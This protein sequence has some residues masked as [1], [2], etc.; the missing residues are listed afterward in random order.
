MNLGN[1]K[2]GSLLQKYVFFIASIVIIAITVIS[3]AGYRHTKKEMTGSLYREMLL[4]AKEASSVMNQLLVKERALTQGLAEATEELLDQEYVAK[5]YEKILVEFVGVYPET[6]GM[7]IGF[8]ENAFKNLKKAAPYAYRDGSTIVPTDEYTTNDFNIWSTEWYKVGTNN[9]KDGGWTPV[10]K[11]PV[12]G[13]SMATIS[14]PIYGKQNALMGCVASDVDIS[15]LKDIVSTMKVGYGG[16]PFLLSNTGDFLTGEDDEFIS[17]TVQNHS[18]SE[19]TQGIKAMLS[20]QEAGFFDFEDQKNDFIIFHAPVQETGWHVILQFNKK[21][22]LASLHDLF[23]FFIVI[24]IISVIVLIVTVYLFTRFVV[25]RPIN[26]IRERLKDIAQGEGD[27]TMRLN[28]KSKDELGE[29][30]SWFDVFMEKM[31]SIIS[32][33]ANDT[34]ELDKSFRDLSGI[35]DELSSHT[36]ASSDRASNVAVVT[37]ELNS[38]ITTV[39]SAMEQATSNASAVGSASEEMSVTISQIV[40]NVQEASHISSSAV[41]Q[42]KKTAEQMGELEQTALAISNITETITDISDKTNLLA[43]NATIEAA[44]AG[45]AGK[46]FA[47]VAN[48]I[49]ELAAQ[50]VEATNDIKN[51]ISG[52]QGTSKISIAAIH[53]IATIINKVN[54]IIGV[55]TTAVEE[56]SL[57]ARDI[58]ANISQSNQ[59]FIEINEHVNQG[60]SIAQTIST[61]INQVSEASGQIA[62]RSTSLTSEAKRLEE[63]STALK[64]I[65]NSFKV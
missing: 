4:Q 44:R 46:G 54:T 18:N 40:E 34:G 35:A 29:L 47:V 39:A 49:K 26:E 33:I 20:S 17:R 52:I 16:K 31:Q 45:E 2:G 65:V 43:L 58:T 55:I 9:G 22:A 13:L 50:T 53:D 51:Q 56:Q 63:L 19:L 24:G 27:L 36:L 8:R 23:V 15:S 30:A 32:Q 12:S 41:E 42:A 10:Y 6:A 1:K 59:G 38:N 60:A 61:D 57:A 3:V 5:D 11:D 7:G 25:I 48:E 37:K 28:T 64:K 62:A 21:L 14:C